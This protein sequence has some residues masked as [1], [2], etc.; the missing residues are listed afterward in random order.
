MVIVG[1][2][3]PSTNHTYTLLQYGV[4]LFRQDMGTNIGSLDINL[5]SVTRVD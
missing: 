2:L 3:D 5:L 4:S 1:T